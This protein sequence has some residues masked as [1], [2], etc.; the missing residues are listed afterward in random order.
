M[1]P[2]DRETQHLIQ[3]RQLLE[4][5]LTAP[6]TWKTRLI[7]RMYLRGEITLEEALEKLRGLKENTAG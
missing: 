4:A 2:Q 6:D 7:M 5:A 1:N 3:Y